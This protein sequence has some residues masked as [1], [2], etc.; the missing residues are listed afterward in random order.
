MAK[1]QNDFLL[2]TMAEK[3]YMYYGSE[4]CIS[5]ITVKNTLSFFQVIC[6][7]NN[8]EEFLKYVHFTVYKIFIH[9]LVMLCNLEND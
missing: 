6:W 7:L 8:F 4:Y 3:T 5:L 9:F 2:G 1:R